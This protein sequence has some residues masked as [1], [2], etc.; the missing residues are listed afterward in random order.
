MT[1]RVGLRSANCISAAASMGITRLPILSVAYVVGLFANDPPYGAPVSARTS[2]T[3]AACASSSVARPAG[4]RPPT[5]T[6]RTSTRAPGTSAPPTACA[7]PI[8]KATARIP[9]GSARPVWN[10]AASSVRPAAST[11]WPRQS[12]ARGILPRAA[13]TSATEPAGTASGGSDAVARSSAVS[14]CVASRSRAA[15][16]TRERWAPAQALDPRQR[17]ACG[18]ERHARPDRDLPRLDVA[19]LALGDLAPLHTATAPSDRQRTRGGRRRSGRRTGGARA[20]RRHVRRPL[21]GQLRVILEEHDA[22][23]HEAFAR[24]HVVLV[25]RPRDCSA[26]G[27]RGPAIERG[28]VER[29]QRSGPNRVEHTRIA[30]GGFVDG[31]GRV[32]RERPAFSDDVGDVR[33]GHV[34]EAGRRCNEGRRV[35]RGGGGGRLGRSTRVVEWIPGERGRRSNYEEREREG[36]GAPG[37]RGELTARTPMVVTG[38]NASAPKTGV[39]SGTSAASRTAGRS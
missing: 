34:V 13:E 27:E 19:P 24:E 16:I 14:G 17:N 37:H 25:V 32:R 4:A 35:H 7:A 11:T 5:G 31:R 23:R 1:V 2:R 28:A 10:A 33:V 6:A 26:V 21:P 15:T 20:G 22:H 29:A 18:R 38:W 8:G 39:R 9:R 12:G 30:A 36:R 3:I